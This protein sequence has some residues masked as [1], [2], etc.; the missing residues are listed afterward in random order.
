M[1]YS[2]LNIENVKWLTC[3]LPVRRRKQLPSALTLTLFVTWVA[4]D[5]VY[6]SLAAN[7]FAM[8]ANSLDTRSNFHLYTGL[9]KQVASKLV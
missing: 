7:D 9:K 2:L 1:T 8:F 5:N 6:S 4:A 3:V